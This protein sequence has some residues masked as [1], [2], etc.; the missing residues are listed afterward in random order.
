MPLGVVWGT[1]GCGIPVVGLPASVTT[2][3]RVAT[4]EEA[5]PRSGSSQPSLL[6]RQELCRD[7]LSQRDLG[8]VT[9]AL[10][11]VMVSQQLRRVGQ[12]LVRLGCFP[13]HGWRVGVCLRARCALRTFWWERGR[14]PPCVH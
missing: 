12:D 10:T 13:G 3:E 1:P 7:L 4:L 2:A 9:M 8:P 5:S 11:V 6:S 14:L